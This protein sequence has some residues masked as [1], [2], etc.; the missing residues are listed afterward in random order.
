MCRYFSWLVPAVV[1]AAA[2]ALSM[3]PV[4]AGASALV[5]G[6][7]C[8]RAAGCEDISSQSCCTSPECQLY[9]CGQSGD[10]ESNLNPYFH[11]LSRP[12]ICIVTAKTPARQFDSS[13]IYTLSENSPAQ[14]FPLHLCT[15]YFCRNSLSSEEPALL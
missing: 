13:K 5:S 7:H 14:D 4:T 3:T 10:I 2:L 12:G 9:Y 11:T 15:S 1:I 6:D 8:R